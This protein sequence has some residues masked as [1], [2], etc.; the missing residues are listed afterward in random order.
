MQDVSVGLQERDPATGGRYVRLT[1]R[2]A[3]S[4]RNRT[5]WAIQ[6]SERSFWRADP[7][8]GRWEDP[9]APAGVVRHELILVG[10][11]DDHRVEL[12]GLSLHYACLVLAGAALGVAPLAV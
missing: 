4:R 12:A 8:G 11:G 7:E 3:G 9:A 10:P 2:P 1:F 5:V 6:A